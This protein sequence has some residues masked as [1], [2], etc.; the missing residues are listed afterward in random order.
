MTDRP[1]LLILAS[2]ATLTL[3][4]A[5]PVAAEG[6]P[7]APAPAPGIGPTS[8]VEAA[9]APAAAE[10]P[11]AAPVAPA[12]AE[13]PAAAPVAPATAEAPAADAPAPTEAAAAPPADQPSGR[14]E[15]MQR[16]EER[17]AKMTAERNRHYGE[18]RER[19]AEVGI[20]LPETPP[21]DQMEMPAMPDMPAMPAGMGERRSAADL[22]AARAAH[23]QAMREHA[24]ELGIDLPE[25]PPARLMSADERRAKMDAMRNMTP[26]E[27]MAARAE[28][29][30]QLRERAAAKGIEMPETP[31]WQAAQ[32]RRKAMQEQWE[33]YR[34]EIDAMSDE[35][36]EAA[37][38]IFGAPP[39]LDAPQAPMSMPMQPPIRQEMPPMPMYQQMPMKRPMDM[40]Q[41]MPMERPMDMPMRGQGP[42]P[43]GDCGGMAPPR[44]MMPNWEGSQGG[45]RMPMPPQGGYGAPWGRGY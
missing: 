34:K 19:A 31:P 32:E 8:V 3:A 43:Q 5:Q 45:N 37:K 36:R 20:Q 17:R 35:Q 40:Y 12:A 7:A 41:Q 22:D 4:L 38:A 26:E 24:K 1:S 27:R 30:Q 33:A 15:A 10:A 13:A 29:Y 6:E 42:C 11:A 9:A 23:Y 44:A 25:T 39:Q 28:S 2:A 14:A 18:L 16:M 21:W